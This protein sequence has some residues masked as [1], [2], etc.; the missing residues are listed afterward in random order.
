M[1]HGRYN[2][3]LLVANI[4]DPFSN[5]V[6]KG[7][8][9]EAARLGADLTIF[10]GKYLGIQDKYDK[11]DTTYEYQYNVL[12]DYAAE[13]GFDHII[14]AIGTI[15]YA[16]DNENKKKF[17]AGLGDTPVLSV[18]ADIEGYDSLEFDNRRPMLD[19]VDMLASQGRK[20]IGI[21][22][23][24]LN[25]N[26]CEERFL[27]FK[28]G[29]EKHGIEL[30][31][32]YVMQSDVSELCR[33]E[34]EALLDNAPELDAIVCAND[35]IA[36]VVYEAV[37][38][39]GLTVGRD[40]AVTGFDDLPVS[41]ELDPPLAT[42]RADAVKLGARA[43][44]KAV[45]KLNGIE[46]TEKLFPSEFIPRESCGINIEKHR[47]PI[48]LTESERIKL[49]EE[50]L[51]RI[52]INNIFVRDAMMFSSDLKHSYAKTMKQLSLIGAMTSFMY[53]LEKPVKHSFNE[54]FPKGLPW[55]FR[56]Y[57]YGNEIHTVPDS[58]Q[59]VSIREVFDNKYL[60]TERQHCFIAADLYVADTQ[61]GIALLEPQN[62]DFFSELELVTYILSSAVRTLDILNNREK[63]LG[64]LK[65]A[66]LALE[67]ES[68]IDELTG[69]YN[70]RGFYLAADNLLEQTGGMEHIV[71][72]ADLDNL[73]LINDLYGHN[74]GDSALILT[75]ECLRKV[76]GDS[77]VIGRAGGDEFIV[78]IPRGELDPEKCLSARDAYV[79]ALNGKG[80]KPYKFN[81]SMGIISCT[82]ENGYDLKAALDRADDQLYVHK[83]KRKREI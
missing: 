78:I 29:L 37:K 76:F 27:A 3:A 80:I 8:M 67:K 11:Y 6:A 2:L 77:A 46:D 68:Q 69:I 18:A 20:H 26:E 83:Q 57:S 60:C 25:N 4:T 39:R 14:A 50:N 34:A 36:M 16:L 45:N 65:T 5:F 51:N 70:R 64:R 49:R 22:V 81:V 33:D 21:M 66:N 54:K 30:P 12:F 9:E 15:A 43:V 31:D 38:A 44:E 13:G 72:Y 73:K 56:S 74:E 35:D 24:D 47:E 75:A 61:Y 42:V 58:E 52:H 19:I 53:T 41:A 48:R 62:S 23:G 55:I 40:I 1:S 59:K 17:L 63:L 28:E 32:R 79:D 10:P 71:C 7:V 82:C